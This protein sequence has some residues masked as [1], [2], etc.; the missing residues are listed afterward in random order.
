MHATQNNFIFV[1]DDEE[2]H[3]NNDNM[4]LISFIYISK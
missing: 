2:Q 3:T 1:L 4:L